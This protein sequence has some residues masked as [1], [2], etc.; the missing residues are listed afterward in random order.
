MSKFK[1]KISYDN[2]PIAKAKAEDLEEFDNVF[3]KLKL[4]F[5]G[6]EVKK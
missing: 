2:V 3:N 6:Y 4:K 5:K 1:L